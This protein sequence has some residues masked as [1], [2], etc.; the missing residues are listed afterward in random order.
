MSA[1]ELRAALDLRHHLDCREAPPPVEGWVVCR[2]RSTG[3]HYY[4][5]EGVG[6]QWHR[7]GLDPRD[8]AQRSCC[9][10]PC[11]VWGHRSRA[12]VK[13]HCDRME[14][15]QRNFEFKVR[16]EGC[17]ERR[18]RPITC[19]RR[20]GG[21]I[22]V[23]PHHPRA[24][25]SQEEKLTKWRIEG[26]PRGLSYYEWCVETIRESSTFEEFRR[27]IGEQQWDEE[28]CVQGLL[29]LRRDYDHI[30]SDSDLSESEEE[31]EEDEWEDYDPE[32][33]SG[34][35][36]GGGRS[37]F[38]FSGAGRKR[39]R[40]GMDP[41]VSE[42]IA[43]Y[44]ESPG[45]ASRLLHH[46]GSN[47]TRS[48]RRFGGKNHRAAHTGGELELVLEEARPSAA[49]VP[50]AEVPSAVPSA[51]VMDTAVRAALAQA[52]RETRAVEQVGLGP[53]PGGASESLDQGSLAP[54]AAAAARGAAYTGGR[55]G[56]ALPARGGVPSEA[57]ADTEAL[58]PRGR[59][60]ATST[61]RRTSSRG[62]AA[63]T[64]E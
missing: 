22:D 5:C 41:L 6:S 9:K 54:A 3:E 35:G 49:A 4:A 31:D 20:P 15:I 46:D 52:Q 1:P 44:V 24:S 19:R 11:A 2:S 17:R 42:A 58:D 62:R 57:S 59:G 56:G 50:S 36:G 16:T 14:R 28:R 38:G 29:A 64:A 30:A 53:S 37:G 21:A 48:G 51:S 23:L 61:R 7:P 13:D 27:I 39:G 47:R 8:P 40:G 60:T 34:G 12:N 55:V 63:S 33:L 26:E 32:Q 43:C 18:W 10:S 45:F 25:L